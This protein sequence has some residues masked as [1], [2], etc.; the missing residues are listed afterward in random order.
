MVYPR[1]PKLAKSAKLGEMAHTHD[2]I[3]PGSWRAK[4]HLK[5]LETHETQ[6]PIYSPCQPSRLP[7]TTFSAS[8]KMVHEKWLQAAYPILSQP[9]LSNTK[10]R[11]QGYTP[12][13]SR[14]YVPLPNHPYPWTTGAQSPGANIKGEMGFGA[15]I[16]KKGVS[17]PKS[18]YSKKSIS[19]SQG[20]WTLGF[21]MEAIKSLRSLFQHWCRSEAQ[22]N[23]F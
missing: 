21:C 11:T 14:V 9:W 6:T 8:I 2:P 19:G 5:L 3:S 23:H 22:E 7:L 20:R 16:A 10:E 17:R 12:Y 13:S 1:W 15:N 18:V 4:I